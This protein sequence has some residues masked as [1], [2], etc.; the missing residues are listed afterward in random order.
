MRRPLD[1]DVEK[2]RLQ[3]RQTVRAA[4][5][6]LAF[7]AALVL[8]Y[9][10]AGA[11]P[12]AVQSLTI[13]PPSLE[14][15]GANRQQHVLVTGRTADGKLIDLTHACEWSTDKPEVARVSGT[16]VQGVADGTAVLRVKAGALEARAAVRVVDFAGFPAVHFANDVVPLFSK[17]GC[18]SAACH[19]KASG[20]NGFKLSVF[21]FDPEA[22]YNALVKEARG[23]RVFPASPEQSLLLLKPTGRMAHGGGRRIE[24]G[25]PDY[26]LLLHWIE[27]GMPAGRADAPHVVALRLRPADRV[28]ATQASQQIL[29]TAVFSDG[30]RR[31]VTASASYH[32]NAPL[33][34]EV[35][36]QGRVRTGEVPGEAAITVN[37]MG[38]VGA[39]R[40]QV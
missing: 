26:E 14:L 20:Q 10:A 25:S 4:L 15:R 24:A 21:G 16:V 9:P 18:N 38:L 37:Y 2:T 12:S 3:T 39:A 11:P 27:Q 31:D 40:F 29:T 33:V 35:D 8:A 5:G 23:R 32:S 6:V 13:E 1:S 17:L 22:D 19:G 36:R 30:S 28:L 34:A 7:V